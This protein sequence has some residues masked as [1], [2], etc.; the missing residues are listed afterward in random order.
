MSG[1]KAFGKSLFNGCSVIVGSICVGIY[2]IML[3]I[4]GSP[5]EMIH[6]L[7][8]GKMIPPMWMWRVFS[9]VWIFLSGVA[10]GLVVYERICHRIAGERELRAYRGGIYFISSFFLT[11]VHYPLF[12]CLER[13]MI[14][15]L[16]AL[17][18]M[19]GAAV[20]SVIWSK[21]SAISSVILAGNAF[22]L[23]YVTFISA[24][25]LIGN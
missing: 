13:L 1:S 20:S 21:V 9:I 6:K 17:L 18:A 5:Y 19:I 12:F 2:V 15:F 3:T 25:L 10:A 11:I 23:L 4:S 14:A 8:I 16:V 22:W 24:C 7:D